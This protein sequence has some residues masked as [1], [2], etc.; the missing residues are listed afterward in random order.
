[1]ILSAVHLCPLKV[2][3]PDIHSEIAKFRSASGK[4]IA[5]FFASSPR[6]DLFLE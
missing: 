4:I 6:H 1:M 5:G 2:R 3:A